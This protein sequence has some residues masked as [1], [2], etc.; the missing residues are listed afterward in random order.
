VV[1]VDG[2][3]MVE[4]AE[5]L[6]YAR[7]REERAQYEAWMWGEVLKRAKKSPAC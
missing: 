7:D 4:L 1:Y 3:A 5:L 2:V 6:R